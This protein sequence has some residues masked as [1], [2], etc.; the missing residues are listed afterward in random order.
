[1][2]RPQRDGMGVCQA[3]AGGG[4]LCPRLYAQPPRHGS[5]RSLSQKPSLPLLA[6]HPP[7]PPSPQPHTLHTTHT[8]GTHDMDIDMGLC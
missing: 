6:R 7:I 5:G 4:Q 2:Q 1:M 3:D 8:H